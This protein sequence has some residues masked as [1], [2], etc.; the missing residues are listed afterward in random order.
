MPQSKDGGYFALGLMLGAAV[1]AALGL[2]YA[3][4]P[5]SQ[6]RSGIS[7]QQLRAKALARRSGAV[8]DDPVGAIAAPARADPSFA[9]LDTTGAA[10]GG[11][12]A[13]AGEE[14]ADGQSGASVL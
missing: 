7:A 9:S 6:T 1:G 5:G 14:A 3:P 13:E 10:R 4:R 11:E 8:G 12:S 2:L